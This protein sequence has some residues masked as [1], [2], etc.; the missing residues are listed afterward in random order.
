M[1]IGDGINDSIALVQA[2]VSIAVSHSKDNVIS[3]DV[4]SEAADI[5]LLNEDIWK[6]VI[7]LD[8]CKKTMYLI[9]WNFLWA[10]LY[11]IIGIPLSAGA[12]F[13]IFNIIIPP[14][15]AG[16]SEILSSVPVVF[17]SLLLN[18]YS[19]PSKQ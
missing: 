11:N 18:K 17:F 2:D 16:L 13:P 8:L 15:L 1:M 14:S 3:T 9:K 7:C 6:V 19:P 10:I 12:L 4:A 5:I